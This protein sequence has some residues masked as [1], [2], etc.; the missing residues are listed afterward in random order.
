[1]TKESAGE[2]EGFRLPLVDSS[3]RWN[4]SCTVTSFWR[5]PES[6]LVRQN[7]EEEPGDPSS[8]LTTGRELLGRGQLELRCGRYVLLHQL[9]RVDDAQLLHQHAELRLERVRDRFPG[10]LGQAP[11]FLLERA[12]CPLPGLVVELLVALIGGTL[13]GGGHRQVGIHLLEQVPGEDRTVE[14]HVLEAGG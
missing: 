1:M 5:T 3:F 9:D 4:D 11:R 14:D 13:G 10:G 7:E 2:C 6:V 8:G 12:P